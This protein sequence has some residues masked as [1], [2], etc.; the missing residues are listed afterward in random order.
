[1]ALSSRPCPGREHDVSQQRRRS[2]SRPAPGPRTHT[3]TPA[4]EVQALSP[5]HPPGLSHQG[6]LGNPRVAS[7]HSTGFTQLRSHAAGPAGGAGSQDD[8]SVPVVPD[9][10]AEPRAAGRVGLGTNWKSPQRAAQSRKRRHTQRPVDREGTVSLHVGPPQHRHTHA[11]SPTAPAARRTAPR[12]P[13]STK[14]PV[15]AVSE[16]RGGGRART[17]GH[18]AQVTR[19]TRDRGVCGTH[20]ARLYLN[21][22]QPASRECWHGR[23]ARVQAHVEWGRPR[24]GDHRAG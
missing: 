16:S 23:A 13:G 20:T 18:R 24:A 21:R 3:A 5:R 22:A 2:S 4:S 6:Q 10:E 11:G 15:P 19:G 17:D 14:R 1:M 9:G 8:G 7:P 12:R